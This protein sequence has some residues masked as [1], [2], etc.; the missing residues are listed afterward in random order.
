MRLLV[1]RGAMSEVGAY[2]LL[3]RSGAAEAGYPAVVSALPSA[4]SNALPASAAPGSVASDD[5]IT[6]IGPAKLS[7]RER[8]G[9]AKWR[10]KLGAGESKTLTYQYERYVS[11]N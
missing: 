3:T 6:A 2:G 9:T 11:S 4:A 7:L 10:L 1:L 5:G 8:E